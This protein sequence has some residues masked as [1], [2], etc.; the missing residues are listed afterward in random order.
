MDWYKSYLI[1]VQ[2]EGRGSRQLLDN[3][4]KKDVFYGF[5]KVTTEHQKGPK[6]GPIP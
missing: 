2:N 3:V 6:M 4:Q 1:D 5:P